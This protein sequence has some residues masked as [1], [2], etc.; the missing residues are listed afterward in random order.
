MIVNWQVSPTATPTGMRA[1]PAK[2]PAFNVAPMQ[3]MMSIR[4]GLKSDVNRKSPTPMNHSG[5]ARPVATAARIRSVKDHARRNEINPAP[6]ALP[7][8]AAA[9]SRA[10]P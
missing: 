10:I 8:R 2:S 5:N 4:S 6:K 7:Q 1:T 3:N 9:S